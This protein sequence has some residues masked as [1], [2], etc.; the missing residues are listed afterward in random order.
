MRGII[1]LVVILLIGAFI[2]SKWPETNLIGR[3]L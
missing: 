2:G 1:W 3:V